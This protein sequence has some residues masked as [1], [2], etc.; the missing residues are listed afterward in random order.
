MLLLERIERKNIFFL[1]EEQTTR[2]TKKKATQPT[3]RREIEFSVE[4]WKSFNVEIYRVLLRFEYETHDRGPPETD[5][6]IF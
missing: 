5:A 2:T 6:E 1:E 3:S 4:C